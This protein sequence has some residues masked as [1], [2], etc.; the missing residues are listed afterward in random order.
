MTVD[1][2]NRPDMKKLTVENCTI[3]QEYSY[4]QNQTT[5]QTYP[6]VACLKTQVNDGRIQYLHHE[7]D[8]KGNLTHVYE[9]NADTIREYHYD[10]TNQLIFERN[11]TQS[12]LILMMPAVILQAKRKIMLPLNG[13]MKMNS[14]KICLQ[15][16]TDRLSHMMKLEIHLPI[17]TVCPLLGKKDVS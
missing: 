5:L 1:S 16:L 10:D 11:E 7:Y 12:A 6:L 9:D 2:L 13:C 8:S 14:G 4:I 17:E 15:V 3:Q